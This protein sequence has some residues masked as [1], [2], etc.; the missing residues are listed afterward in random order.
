MKKWVNMSQEFINQ[1]TVEHK[2]KQICKYFLEGRCI[3]VITPCVHPSA[4]LGGG[5][6]EGAPC[7]SHFGGCTANSVWKLSVLSL[8]T[9]MPAESCVEK[10]LLF[11]VFSYNRFSEKLLHALV[12][13]SGK[14]TRG[15][16]TNLHNRL[17]YQRTLLLQPASGRQQEEEDAAHSAVE[18]KPEQATLLQKKPKKLSLHVEASAAVEWSPLDV[19]G[20]QQC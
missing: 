10:R 6:G 11:H 17:R 20:V 16:T 12:S 15:R 14:T 19:R 7:F 3:K 9:E 8:H 1:H 5:R 2:G 18:Q 13:V 4:A